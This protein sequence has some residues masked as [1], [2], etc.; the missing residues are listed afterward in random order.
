MRLDRCRTYCR[1]QGQRAI[2]TCYDWDPTPFGQ[3]VR[4]GAPSGRVAPGG[5]FPGLKPWAEVYSPFGAPD[6]RFQG[7]KP[8]EVYSPFGT[9]DGRFQG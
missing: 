7:L 1:A 8:G 9:P 3:D 2:E 5:R 6:G 4:S